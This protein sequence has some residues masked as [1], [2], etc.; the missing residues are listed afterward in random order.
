MRLPRWLDAHPSESLVA[1][2][3]AVEILVAD[4]EQPSRPTTCRTSR[5]QGDVEGIVGDP[6]RRL[7]WRGNAG[8]IRQVVSAK[9]HGVRSGRFGGNRR[10][11]RGVGCARDARDSRRQARIVGA[12]RETRWPQGVR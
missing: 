11:D 9:T 1:A 10:R 12:A 3:W 6:A 7:Q 2:A 5:R 4:V 8:A